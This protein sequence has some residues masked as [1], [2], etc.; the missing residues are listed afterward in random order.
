M[1]S[2]LPRWAVLLFLPLVAGS[3]LLMH[4][5][6]AG[7]SHGVGHGTHEAAH[8]HEGE[9]HPGRADDSTDGCRG[10]L[11]HVVMTCVAVIVAVT[12]WQLGRRGFVPRMMT[13]RVATWRARPHVG[14]LRARDPAWV[15]WSVMTC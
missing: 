7:V 10:C 3:L 4:G 12:A 5:L 13:G 8:S 9:A 2:R 15:Q 1:T 6:G 11:A 14:L